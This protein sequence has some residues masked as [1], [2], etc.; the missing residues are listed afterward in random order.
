MWLASFLSVLH[1]RL[2]TQLEAYSKPTWR[3]LAATPFHPEQYNKSVL[4]KSVDRIL[5]TVMQG[6]RK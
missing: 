1:D 3:V 4:G 2:L 5:S 6:W